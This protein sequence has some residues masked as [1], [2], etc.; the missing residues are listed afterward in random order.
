MLA[1]EIGDV[2][3]IKLTEG[4]SV[5]VKGQKMFVADIGEVGGTSAI[6]IT[7]KLDKSSAEK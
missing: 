4:L 3:P 2:F 6:T 1:M 5:I 7:R